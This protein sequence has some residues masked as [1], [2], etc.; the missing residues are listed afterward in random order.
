MLLKNIK[1][2]KVSSET[3][4]LEIFSTC[5]KTSILDEVKDELKRLIIKYECQ[6]LKEKENDKSKK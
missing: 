3:V 5:K 6:N 4:L 1:H 2:S